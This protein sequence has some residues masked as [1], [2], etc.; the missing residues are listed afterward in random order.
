MAR[1]LLSALW[2]CGMGLA[3][4]ACGGAASAPAPTATSTSATARRAPTA[5]PRPYVAA[6]ATPAAVEPSPTPRCPDPYIDGVPY[7]PT[8]GAPLRLVPTGSPPALSRYQPS[9]LAGDPGLERVVRNAI[10]GEEQHIAVV[11]KNLDDNRGTAI[12]SGRRFYAASLYK[13]WVLAEAFHQRAAG[14]LSFGER[15]RVTDF[16]ESQALNEGEL[17]ACDEVSV[18]DAL[19]RMM[20]VSDNVAAN[21]MLDRVGAGNVNRA[22]SGLGLTD[23]GFAP[24]GSMPTTAADMALLLEATQRGRVVSGQV[25]GEML[26]FL[27]LESIDD[28]LP[29]LL[30]AQTRIAHKTGNWDDATHDAGIIFSPGA[31]YVIVV[32]TDYGYEDDGASLIARLSKAVYDY[33]NGG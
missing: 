30:P 10:R 9:P 26:L 23:S 1:I 16:Y 8:P 22:M 6:T 17:S 2:L 5:S 32:L 25:S 4:L 7:I 29:A 12:D 18:E 33:Y 15:Y 28:R 19:A 11:V 21:L 13:T 24:D 14:L 20:R 27:G 31:T 3:L